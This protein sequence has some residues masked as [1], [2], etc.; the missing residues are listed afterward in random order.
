MKSIEVGD[1]V[2]VNKNLKSGY[3]VEKNPK[4]GQ[5]FISCEIDWFYNTK[6]I[7]DFC[8]HWKAVNSN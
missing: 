2:V 4:Q 1:K 3:V 6:N 5:D 7:R 8:L